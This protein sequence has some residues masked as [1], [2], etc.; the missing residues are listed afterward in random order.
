MVFNSIAFLVFITMVY[1]L[2]RLVA[3][4]TKQKVVLLMASYFFYMWWNP[5][6][7]ILVLYSTA[8][9]YYAGIKIAESTSDQYRKRWLWFS[10]LSNLSLLIVFKYFNFF[11]DTV[12][13]VSQHF[14]T[15]PGW[16]LVHIILPLGISF[17]TFQSM[18]Y[19]IDVYRGKLTP[20]RSFFDF[21]LY[22]S[23]F[24]Q[25]IAGPIIRAVDFLPQLA[26]VRKLNFSRAVVLLFAKGL[27]KKVVIADNLA[28]ATE[29]VF[30]NVPM[31]SGGVILITSFFCYI[32]LYCDFSGYS[33]MAIA[34]GRS[35]GFQFPSNFNKPMH[36]QSLT[37]FWR[38]W[39]ITL[40]TWFRDYVYVPL[41]GNR[42]YGYLN[43]FV[44]MLVAGIWHG[45]GWNFILWGAIHGLL[46]VLEK[47]AGWHQ[48]SNLW[49][50]LYTQLM[51]MVLCG[52]FW[53]SG[54][55]VL[56]EVSQQ[57]RHFSVS[58]VGIGYMHIYFV[59]IISLVFL[60]FQYGIPDVHRKV[61]KWTNFAYLVF[62]FVYG[63]VFYTLGAAYREPFIYFQF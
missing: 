23:F 51:Y 54:S 9:D 4:N 34:L 3:G 48:K 58:M 40:S 49:T 59:T 29:A 27:F 16:S 33:D 2:L 20:V 12:L 39:H 35:M 8:I 13:W 42:K 38:R 14:G 6:F 21:S 22:I 63:V 45:A 1:G 50:A 57:F 55:G 19:S 52:L 7:I 47:Y 26:V 31:Y 11:Q 56:G 60:L 53:A 25:M 37:D 10:I 36:A 28:Y 18:S 46:L 41:G 32:Q 61:E 30:G 62:W 44:V 5:A 15:Q 43:L 24:P 17:Y